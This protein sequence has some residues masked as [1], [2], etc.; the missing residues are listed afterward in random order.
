MFHSTAGL[1]QNRLP[2]S[3][4]FLSVSNSRGRSISVSATPSRIERLA[5][6]HPPPFPD[7]AATVRSPSGARGCA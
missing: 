5:F 7:N 2:L 6:P 3:P 1:T 4:H